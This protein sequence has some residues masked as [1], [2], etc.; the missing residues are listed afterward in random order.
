MFLR[1]W[2]PFPDSQ[3]VLYSTSRSCTVLS[4]FCTVLGSYL[5]LETDKPFTLN[6]V[7][8]LVACAYEIL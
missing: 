7:L 5:S 4:K 3:V 2:E 1:P 8:L 6:L